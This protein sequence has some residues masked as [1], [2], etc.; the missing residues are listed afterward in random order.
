MEETK[1]MNCT[2]TGICKFC[3]QSRI[4]EYSEDEWLQAV[5]ESNMSIEELADLEAMEQCTCRE[6][7][8]WRNT[9]RVLEQTGKNIE[10]MFRETYPEIADILQEAKSMVWGGQIRKITVATH[11]SG[12]VLMVRNNEK[13]DIRYTEK[14]EKKMTAS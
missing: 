4:V 14:K 6:G 8:G 12:T 11:E 9:R 13:L 2:K 3:G 1:D 10:Y 5:A 7:A